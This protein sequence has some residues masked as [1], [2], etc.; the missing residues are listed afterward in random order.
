MSDESPDGNDLYAKEPDDFV[1]CHIERF[2]N[3]AGY[4]PR[5]LIWF[6]VS[7]II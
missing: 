6:V 5:D 7:G 4:V 2:A 3:V 1:N